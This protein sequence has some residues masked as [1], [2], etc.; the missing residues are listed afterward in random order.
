[1]KLDLKLLKK[2][3]KK[4]VYIVEWRERQPKLITQYPKVSVVM[5]QLIMLN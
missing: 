1:M 5:L 3:L 2:I 4:S